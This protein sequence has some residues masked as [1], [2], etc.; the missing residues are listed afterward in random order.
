MHLGEIRIAQ[1]LGLNEVL[2]DL[3]HTRASPGKPD[4]PGTAAPKPY[5]LG[6]LWVGLSRRKPNAFWMRRDPGRANPIPKP[7][8]GVAGGERPRGR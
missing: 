2:L 8:T 1:K 4:P 5:W 3:N 7:R 6:Y